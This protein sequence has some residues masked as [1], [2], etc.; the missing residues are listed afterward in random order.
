MKAKLPKFCPLKGGIEVTFD[1]V[2]MV[3]RLSLA[4]GEH[5]KSRPVTEHRNRQRLRAVM[6]KGPKSILG[7]EVLNLGAYQA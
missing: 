5:P 1:E 3:Y 4:I 6:V 7:I 2:V